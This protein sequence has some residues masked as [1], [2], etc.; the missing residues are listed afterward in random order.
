ML[1]YLRFG[2][3]CC[4]SVHF[5][6]LQLLL[7]EAHLSNW[8]RKSNPKL[9]LLRRIALCLAQRPT[10]LLAVRMNYSPDNLA[11]SWRAK[12][13]SIY[14]TVKPCTLDLGTSLYHNTWGSLDPTNGARRIH[15]MPFVCGVFPLA[16]VTC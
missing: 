12:L 11:S 9:F 4:Q 6:S 3:S 14:S 10:V 5:S 13:I 16:V 7:R 15:S 2:R 8:Q 1:I